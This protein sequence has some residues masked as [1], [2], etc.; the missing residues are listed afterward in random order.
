MPYETAGT[1]AGSS[2]SLGH[3]EQDIAIAKPMPKIMRVFIAYCDCPYLGLACALPARLT[4]SAVAFIHSS[5][6]G[7]ADFPRPH[8]V[9]GPCCISLL[10]FL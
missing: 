4:F 6:L 9:C 3:V 10:L 5:M 2:D 7:E 1:C 8:V